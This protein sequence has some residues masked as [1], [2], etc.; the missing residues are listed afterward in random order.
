MGVLAAS[1]LIGWLV[2]LL[3]REVR[4]VEPEREVVASIARSF[5]QPDVPVTHVRVPSVHEVFEQM[6]DEE[7]WADPT[8]GVLPDPGRP[9]VLVGREGDEP[10]R[11]N[12]NGSR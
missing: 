6:R 10:W 1:G 2:W 8:D 7:Q 4:R 11:P 5:V 9:D 12:F 3:V